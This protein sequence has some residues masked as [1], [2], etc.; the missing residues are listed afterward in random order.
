MPGV[1]YWLISPEI[2]LSENENVLIEWTYL[3]GGPADVTMQ[4]SQG[5]NDTADFTPV[6]TLEYNPNKVDGTTPPFRLNDYYQDNPIRVAFRITGVEDDLYNDF[7]IERIVMWNEPLG[8]TDRTDA[9]MAVCP[10]PSHGTVTV[11]LPEAEGTLTLFDATGRQLM[12]RSIHAQ[13]TTLDVSSL[14]TGIYMVQFTS[15]RGTT[16][17]RLAVR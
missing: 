3:F 7:A 10:N 8:I 16:V 2:D 5:G 6:F 17:S 4:V 15:Q 12:Q 9:Q 11:S 13:N 1:D 14:P